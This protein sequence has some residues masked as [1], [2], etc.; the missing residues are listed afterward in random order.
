MTD[1]DD[2]YQGN[3]RRRFS[4]IDF[5]TW[6]ELRQGHSV[7]ETKLLDISL[8]GLLV[9]QPQG[10]SINKHQPLEAVINLADQTTIMMTVTINHVD[11]DHL[12]FSCDSIDVDSITHLRRLIELNLGDPSAAERELAE[13]I[14]FD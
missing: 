3:D 5:N 2:T 9:D 6:V 8:K 4:R 10:L 1:S 7:W 11:N 13:L 12:G 14:H